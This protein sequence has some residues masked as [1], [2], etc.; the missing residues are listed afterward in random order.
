M[1]AASHPGSQCDS[2]TSAVLSGPVAVKER[3]IAPWDSTALRPSIWESF[4]AR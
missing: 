2:E 1:S 4:T 3:R